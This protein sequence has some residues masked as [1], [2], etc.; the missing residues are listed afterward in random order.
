MNK[1]QSG[2]KVTS[3]R[4][5]DKMFRLPPEGGAAGGGGAALCCMLGS[6][7]LPHVHVL[8]EKNTEFSCVCGLN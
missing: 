6:A 1:S 3:F 8:L 2:G 4:L 7:G 5:D